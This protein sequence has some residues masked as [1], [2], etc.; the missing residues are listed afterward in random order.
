MLA[1]SDG[2]T[3]HLPA[4]WQDMITKGGLTA[5]FLVCGLAGCP[6]SGAEVPAPTTA[7]ATG[8]AQATTRRGQLIPIA[9]IVA[10]IFEHGDGRA[11]TGCMVIAPP[12]FLA[13]EEARQIIR[14]ELQKFGLQ[15]SKHDVEFKDIQMKSIG[16]TLDDQLT[17][18]RVEISRPLGI[19]LIDADRHVAVQYIAT[20]DCIP[21]DPPEDVPGPVSSSGQEYNFKKTAITIADKLKSDGNDHYFGVFYDPGNHIDHTALKGKPFLARLTA[22]RAAEAEAKKKSKEQ[23]RQQV[24]DFA[25]WLRQRGVI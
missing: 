8:P 16:W 6:E 2:L 14:E 9:A 24:R 15:F 1:E 17:Y 5:A 13:E 20:A 19:D 23:L 22:E 18:N 25:E 4:S 3:K 10:P 12:V 7:S 11:A 21:P